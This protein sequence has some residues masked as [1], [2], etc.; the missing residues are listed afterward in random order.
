M[1]KKSVGVVYDLV[2]PEHLKTLAVAADAVC[3]VVNSSADFPD[4]AFDAS[5]VED[6]CFGEDSP[7]NLTELTSKNKCKPSAI[8]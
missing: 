6:E 1:V 3:L 5:I 8:L 4:S 7:W 2:K